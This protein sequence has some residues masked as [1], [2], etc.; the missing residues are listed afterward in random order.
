M[1]SIITPY[2]LQSGECSLEQIGTISISSKPAELDIVNKQILPPFEEI[3]FTEDATQ[4][5]PGLIKY[6]AQKK[7]YSADVAE[8]IL[9]D[10]CNEWKDRLADGESFVFETLGS[11][12]KNN[13]GNIYFKRTETTQFLKPVIAERVLHEN[14]EHNVLI[15]DKEISSSMITEYNIEEPIKK[16]KWWLWALI[17]AVVAFAALTYHFSKHNFNGEGT[18]NQTHIVIDSAGATHSA[19]SGN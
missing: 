13:D 4:S 17:L 11:L 6:I 19:I 2:F 1:Q 12:Q 14:A 5:S 8:S 9:T 10:F 7:G 16:S 15:G 18:G 3:I